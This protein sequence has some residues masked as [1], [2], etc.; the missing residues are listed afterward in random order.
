MHYF[1]G[2]YSHTSFSAWCGQT[3]FHSKGRHGSLRLTDN[4]PDD[5]P[6]CATCEGR[7]IGAGQLGATV[8]AGR[9]VIFTPRRTA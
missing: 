7:A 8:I 4:P 6:L 1:N 3:G 2:N 9:Q 5:L